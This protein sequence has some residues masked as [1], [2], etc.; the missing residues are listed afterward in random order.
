M[1]PCVYKIINVQ[2]DKFYVGSAKD[3]KVRFQA[4]RHNLRKGQHHCD[5]LQRSWNKYGEDA[6]VFAVISK[7]ATREEAFAEEQ[8]WL[9]A[10]VGKPHCYNTSL[11]ANGGRVPGFTNSPE[12]RAKIS[13]SRKGK[14]A[15][16][17]HYR[18]GQTV[19][20]EI[21]KKIGDTQR[22]RTRSDEF[23]EKV[24][25]SLRRTR[26]IPVKELTS[27]R[28]WP[29]AADCREEL[30]ITGATLQ[31][32]LK[33]QQPVTKG[34]FKGLWFVDDVDEPAREI[35]PRKERPRPVMAGQPTHQKAIFAIEPD[36]TVHEYESF[37]ELR[38]QTGL[39]IS[40]VNRSL[41]DGRVLKRGQWKGWTFRYKDA[42]DERS[43]SAPD[44]VSQ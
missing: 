2:N 37:A 8:K 39:A 11:N 17:E 15:G 27:G 3:K 29:S 42:P 35:R 40:T 33:S 22:G 19:S 26:G 43:S 25:Q 21:R 16:A 13:K 7:H 9:D 14:M 1:Q 6:F 23:R 18:Y 20:E 4:H 36:G 10:H 24:K 28:T 41:K 44:T 12:T 32:A 5:H 30:G 31:R 38:R 34:K